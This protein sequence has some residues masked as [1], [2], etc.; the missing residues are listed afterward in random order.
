MF[1]AEQYIISSEF[2]IEKTVTPMNE[3]RTDEDIE[4]LHFQKGNKSNNEKI[5]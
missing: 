2:K 5:R 4:E 1:C 3:L